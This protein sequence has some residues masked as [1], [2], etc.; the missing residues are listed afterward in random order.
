MSAPDGGLK[1]VPCPRC[2]VSLYISHD[3]IASS[4]AHSIALVNQ[5]ALGMVTLIPYISLVSTG[6]L[7][8]DLFNWFYEKIKPRVDAP[9]YV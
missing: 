3:Y 5:G 6:K 8:L 4:S 9:S 1:S 2:Y 7:S